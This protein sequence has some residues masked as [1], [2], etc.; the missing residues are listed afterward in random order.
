MKP[1]LYQNF[2]LIHSYIQT[3]YDNTHIKVVNR[4]SNIELVHGWDDYGRS[5]KKKQHN[6]KKQ[7]D[8]SPSKPPFQST[9]WKIFPGERSKKKKRKT[10]KQAAGICC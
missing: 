1:Y 8:G 2:G 10:L 5:S 7:I 9:H 3:I 4:F 6:K